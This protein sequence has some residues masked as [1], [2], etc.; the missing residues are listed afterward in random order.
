AEQGPVTGTQPLLPIQH[1]FFEQAFIHQNHWNMAVL[2]EVKQDMDG[3][4]L[5]NALS[6]L[7]EHHD[8]LRIRFNQTSSGWQQVNND[9]HENAIFSLVDLSNELDTSRI[10]ETISE[11]QTSLDL[12]EGPLLR[13]VYFNCGENHPDL[14]LT[15]VHHLVV[16]GVS[17]QILLQDLQMVYQQ[18][19][20]G[21]PV[22]LPRKTTSFKYW[23][24]KLAA[25]ANS[26]E[27][28]REQTYW[29]A[30]IGEQIA[31]LPLDYGRE[32]ALLNTV[33]S[34]QAVT[35][36]L[37]VEETR[38]LLHEVPAAY[39]TQINDILLT[40]LTQAITKWTGGSQLLVDLEGHGR[41][42]LFDDV[43]LSRTV[44]W[45]AVVHPVL[46]TL[47]QHS[48]LG[49]VIK[50]IKEQLHSIP[51]G[52]IGYGLLRYLSKNSEIREKF[53]S[54]PQAEISFN[55]MGQFDQLLPAA[56]RFGVSSIS[57]GT[58]EDPESKRPYL[59]EVS[60]GV[61]NGR[62][63]MTW[64][65]SQQ[66]HRQDT[67]QT[68]AQDYIDFLTSLIKHCQAPETG[69]YTPS[70]FPK[71]RLQQKELDL[72]LSKLKDM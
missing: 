42:L 50:S 46:L 45:F 38:A 5:E 8:A 14:L 9:S 11:A 16:D 28:Q 44:G 71:A 32:A 66:I 2:L 43:D 72:F 22:Q 61:Q 1:W 52:G 26:D 59:L 47:T 18:L 55:Y 15:I 4:L 58:T 19:E 13:V 56:S 3:V 63:Q 36:S 31:R 17:W 57:P 37:A 12:S 70:D 35:V 60:G 27:M 29:P 21:I 39:N 68:L 20:E 53:G 49:E 41:E 10:K 64:F 23:A 65:Y 24:E 25:Y 40:A 6:Y 48:N 7:V 51:H 54:L 33:S 62:L 34:Q 30:E 67:I 69:G